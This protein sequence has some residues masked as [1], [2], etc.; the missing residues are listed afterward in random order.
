MSTPSEV[1]WEVSQYLAYHSKYT[2]EV[3]KG[4]DLMRDVPVWD[5]DVTIMG[6]SQVKG[7]TLPCKS[8]SAAMKAAKR[9]MLRL[10][11]KDK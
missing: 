6:I 10:M 7:V 1:K 3:N 11:K 9:C 4:H 5:W 8:S 2:L